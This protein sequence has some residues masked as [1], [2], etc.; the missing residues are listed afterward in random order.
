M[1]TNIQELSSP[2]DIQALP[3]MEHMGL[4]EVTNPNLT[5][6]KMVHNKSASAA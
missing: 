6:M 2:Q 3:I 5:I 1:Y 4:D